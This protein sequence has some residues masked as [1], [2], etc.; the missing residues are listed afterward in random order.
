MNCPQCHDRLTRANTHPANPQ[1]LNCNDC[2]RGEPSPVFL[3]DAIARC[4]FCYEHLIHRRTSTTRG[5]LRRTLAGFE[6]LGRETQD[7]EVCLVC[8]SCEIDVA[9][10][11]GTK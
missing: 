7:D 2:Q 6:L 1:P 11:E 9:L 3:D 4:P 8:I 10:P 5:S